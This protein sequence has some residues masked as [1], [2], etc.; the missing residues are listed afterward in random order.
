[1]RKEPSMWRAGPLVRPALAAAIGTLLAIGSGCVFSADSEEADGKRGDDFAYSKEPLTTRTAVLNN[2]L[3]AYERSDPGAFDELLDADFRFVFQEEDAPHGVPDSW[4]ADDERRATQ[5]LLDA[6]AAREA[7]LAPAE[8]IDLELYGF[9]RLEEKD[10]AEFT[11]KK[12]VEDDASTWYEITLRYSLGVDVDGDTYLCDDRAVF[13][14]R[15]AQV[16][17]GD[18]WRLVYW[19]DIHEIGGLA[20]GAGVESVSWGAVKYLYRGETPE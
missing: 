6:E 10:W 16:P 19:H 9:R 3:Y 1:M 8:N 13:V 12:H 2:L 11:G 20:A 4:A 15:P 5:N 7:F 18:E 14:V 17:A